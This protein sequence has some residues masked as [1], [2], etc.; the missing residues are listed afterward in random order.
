MNK[1][2]NINLAGIVFHIDED[3]FEI[4]NNYLNAL[5]IILKMKK[6]LMKY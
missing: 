4:L 5:K 6:V 2:L 1:T 3:A